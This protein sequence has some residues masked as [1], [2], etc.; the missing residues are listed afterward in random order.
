LAFLSISMTFLYRPRRRTQIPSEAAEAFELQPQIASEPS[1]IT[2]NITAPPEDETIQP[3][4]RTAIKSSTGAKC[5]VALITLLW[6]SGC[7]A[8]VVAILFVTSSRYTYETQNAGTGPMYIHCHSC[9]RW[10]LFSASR[11]PRIEGLFQP[12]GILHS[13]ELHYSVNMDTT[14]YLRLRVALDGLGSRHCYREFGRCS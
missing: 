2:P 11:V 10:T 4:F 14:F 12:V 9:L 5:L 3:G 13:W 6:F 1:A 7:V 8:G